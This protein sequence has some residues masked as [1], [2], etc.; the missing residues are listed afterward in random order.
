MLQSFNVIIADTTCFILLDKI[1]EME[2]LKSVFGKITTTPTI[3]S[4]FGRPLPDWINIVSVH[5]I[6]LQ[7]ALQLEVDA[8]EASAIALASELAPAFL[9]L[10]DL[11]ARRL[12]KQL[13]FEFTGTLGLILRA[14]R[15]GHIQLIKPILEKMQKTN[16]RISDKLYQDV[17][18]QAG[19][20]F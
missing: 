7:E 14:K 6:R 16:F 5:D 13:N 2:L 18:A 15:T 12:A 8:G 4:E 20:A 3:V 1:G 10:D 9:I 19:E 11:E 17:L